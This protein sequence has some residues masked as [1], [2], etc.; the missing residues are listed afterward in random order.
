MSFFDLKILNFLG[1]I[2]FVLNPVYWG[3]NI[4][5]KDGT[6]TNLTGILKTQERMPKMAFVEGGCFDMG[7][8]Y[9]EGF[10]FEDD[11]PVHEVCVDGFYLAEHEVRKSD[12]KIFIEET[13]YKT[14]VENAGYCWSWGEDGW[15]KAI[16]ANW[17]SPNFSQNGDHP[18]V[19]VSWNDA[20]GYTKW[21]S[22]KTGMEFRLPT[23]AEWEYAARGGGNRNEFS[24]SFGEK[25]LFL[26]GNFC[27]VNCELGWKRY[28]LDDGYKYT[29]PVKMYKP[30]SLGLYDMSGNVWEWVSDWYDKNYYQ[31]RIR[32]N[33]KGPKEP[34]DGFSRVLRGGSWYN[35]TI[36]LRTCFRYYDYAGFGNYNRGFRLARTPS[37]IEAEKLRMASIL[38]TP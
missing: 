12:F 1:L 14:E 36:A 3:S 28:D 35:L 33:P 8:S 4:S 9:V 34:S 26:Y 20:V 15:E 17:R 7:G 21:L 38:E 16:G 13:G 10:Q 19:C 29:A 18:V 31:R 27:D 32:N 24:G 23:E 2:F 25:D 5:N 37:R 30:N 6:Q 11:K 22:K